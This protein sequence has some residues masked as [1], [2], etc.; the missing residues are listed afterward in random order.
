[1]PNADGPLLVHAFD[2][3]PNR[4]ASEGY[5]AGFYT[6]AGATVAFEVHPD[7]QGLDPD[8]TRVVS[9]CT[10]NPRRVHR[11]NT[12]H[13]CTYVLCGAIP[14]FRTRQRR[15]TDTPTDCF[16]CR[17]RAISLGMDR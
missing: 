10:P 1:M 13:D 7:D 5:S 11:I 17:E 14:L 9:D 15:V 2:F 8:P 12:E 3:D 16:V 4:A 6:L